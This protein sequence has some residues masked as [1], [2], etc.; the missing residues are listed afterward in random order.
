[1][2]AYSAVRVDGERLYK[3]SRK[4]ETV[5]VAPERTVTI[6]SLELLALTADR[7]KLR[8]ACSK[9]T[10]IRS[11]AHD[12]GRRLGCGAYLSTLRRDRVGKFSLDQ[13]LTLDHIDRAVE[14]GE[15]EASLLPI[16]AALDFGSLTVEDGFC[17]RLA[18]GVRPQRKDIAGVNG[19][20]RSGDTVLLKDRRGTVLAIGTATVAS[21][22]LNGLPSGEIVTYDRVLR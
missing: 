6:H 10:Y 1:V 5:V 19:E 12:I 2:P 16:D 8:V 18:D 22:N 14:S 3:R 13:A 11:L 15:F 17:P 4:G 20:F 21:A 9:G 7:I